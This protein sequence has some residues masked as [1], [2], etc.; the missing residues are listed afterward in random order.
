MSCVAA[1]ESSEFK[2]QNALLALPLARSPA[3]SPCPAATISP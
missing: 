2:R 3:T 1:P